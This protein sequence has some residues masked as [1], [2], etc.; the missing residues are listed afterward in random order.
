MPLLGGTRRGERGTPGP[1]SPPPACHRKPEA[2]R[3]RPAARP[4]VRGA[5]PGRWG[6]AGT[7]QARAPLYAIPLIMRCAGEA[8]GTQRVPS[9]CRRR[10]RRHPG[11]PRNPQGSRSHRRS[12]RPAPPTRDRA[13][14]AH[15]PPRTTL[16]ARGFC[17][18]KGC[19][20]AG[21]SRGP[22]SRK[23]T[24]VWPVT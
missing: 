5:P 11:R 9:S 15:A 1:G 20:G 23:G 16:P 24:M 6:C 21:V 2:A 10:R 22:G 19:Q 13:A 17:V 12:S 3:A 8:A 7:R 4:R 14:P 18:I